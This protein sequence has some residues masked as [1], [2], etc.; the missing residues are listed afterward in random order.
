MRSRSELADVITT[1]RINKPCWL[2]CVDRLVDEAMEE[3]VIDIELVHRPSP[4]CCER[5]DSADGGE[6]D[7]GALG[8]SIVDTGVLCDALDDP[9]RLVPIQCAIVLVFVAEDPLPAHNNSLH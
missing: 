4:I 3:G 9:A 8:F 1:I 6:F 5:E 2:L 7:D